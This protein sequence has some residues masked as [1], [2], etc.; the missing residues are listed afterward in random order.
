MSHRTVLPACLWL[1]SAAATAGDWQ[2]SGDLRTGVFASEREA[3]NGATSDVT[4]ARARLRVALARKLAPGWRFRARVAGRYGTEQDGFDAYLRGYAPTATGTELGDTTLDELYLDYAPAGADWSLRVGRFQSKFELIGVA[5]KSLDRNDSPSTDISWTDGVHWRWRGLP[6]WQAHVVLQHNHREGPGTTARA[7]LDFRDGSS[8]VGL[9]A[10]LE[11]T[12]P[13]G[14]LVQRMFAVTWLP[15]ALARDGIALPAREDYLAFTARA[16]AAWPLGKDGMRWLLGA[17]VGHAP[18]TPR[19]SV[20]GTGDPARAGGTAWQVSAN[21][22]NFAPGHGVGVVY[23]R[24][25]AGWLLSPDFRN[26]DALAEI[27]WQWKIDANLSAEARYRWREELA[28][29]AVAA[30]ARVDR[31]VYARI[32]WKF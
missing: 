7:P 32:T 26:N 8:R 20:V 31:D 15:D 21:L 19:G 12:Q 2:A 23:G 27:R 17:E 10:G 28:V 14:P 13:L 30:Q 18:G 5:A 1:L 9:F 25:E 11:A 24:A 29:P 22:E 3:R 16:A 4:E 6:G